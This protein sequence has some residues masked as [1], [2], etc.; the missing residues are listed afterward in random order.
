MWYKDAKEIQ[1]SRKKVREGNNLIVTTAWGKDEGIYQCI[2]SNG[3]DTIHQAASLI[4][5]GLQFIFFMEFMLI[6]QKER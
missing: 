6:F 5:G 3:I 1:Y 2:A 4:V